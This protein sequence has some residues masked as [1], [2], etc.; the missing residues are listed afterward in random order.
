MRSLADNY[1][2]EAIKNV[3]ALLATDSDM[4]LLAEVLPVPIE[5]ANLDWHDFIEWRLHVEE[6][7][8]AA[9]AEGDWLSLYDTSVESARIAAYERYNRQAPENQYKVV[10][11]VIWTYDDGS[12]ELRAS[13]TVAE[14]EQAAAEIVIFNLVDNVW[15]RAS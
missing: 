6:E 11:Q 7:L 14:S 1:G 15:K 5:R 2:L 12:A 3:L 9:R 13:V 10:D 4:S 8:I